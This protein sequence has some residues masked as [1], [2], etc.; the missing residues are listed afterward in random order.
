MKV[1]FLSAKNFSAHNP[2]NILEDQCVYAPE[3]AIHA[4]NLLNPTMS[5]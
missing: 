2:S 5:R 4:Y 3:V 1:K